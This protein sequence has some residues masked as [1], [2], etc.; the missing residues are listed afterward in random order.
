MS[1]FSADISTISAPISSWRRQPSHDSPDQSSEDTSPAWRQRSGPTGANLYAQRLHPL[2][3][4]NRFP[5][6][7]NY[8]GFNDDAVSSVSSSSIRSDPPLP[9]TRYKGLV[10][11]DYGS[12]IPGRDIT[13]GLR[14]L[15]DTIRIIPSL[16]S[17]S[18]RVHLAGFET[19]ASY[20]WL[21]LPTPTMLI[22]GEDAVSTA[23]T[24]KDI[25]LSMANPFASC[26]GTT[27]L[28]R[29]GSADQ[30]STR[31]WNV[32]CVSET[33]RY[34][35]AIIS[36]LTNIYYCSLSDQNGFR[37]PNCPLEPMIQ[38]VTLLQPAFSFATLDVVCDR[39][40]LRKPLRWI[41]GDTTKPFRIGAEIL[42]EE[43]GCLTLTRWEARDKETGI[44]ESG[45]AGWGHSFVEAMTS[46][47]IGC[48]KA[49]DY[50]SI[51]R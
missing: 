22:P 4:S 31:Q 49:C 24:S 39:N 3:R 32:I 13:A 1:S 9:K 51:A 15:L 12:M 36:S 17:F 47:E 42:G 7:S 37:S 27:H 44:N 50:H 48:E 16:A 2:N 10:I 30:A 45:I 8:I 18:D 19:L 46:P 43:G 5:R 25:S 11:G 40:S 28:D 41:S 20:N 14:R 34:C 35:E 38:A 23:V 33:W 26:R 21:D 6:R 29:T